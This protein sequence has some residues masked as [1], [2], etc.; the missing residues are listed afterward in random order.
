MDIQVRDVS[1][2]AEARS[3]RIDHLY[4]DEAQSGAVENRKQLKKLLRACD[5]GEIGILIIPSLDRLSRDVRIAENLFH[6][7]EQLRIRVLIADMPDYRGENRRDVL[8]RQIREAIAEDNRK[9]IIERLCKGRQERV[10]RGNVPGGT[11]PYGYVRV[12][13]RLVENT[14][15]ALVIRTIFE[16]SGLG[17]SS[18]EIAKELDDAGRKQRN[19]HQW[20]PRQVRFIL[21]RRSFYESGEL[22]YGDI[23]GTNEKLILISR[24]DDEY[25]EKIDVGVSL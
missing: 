3:L 7:F 11:A 18:S 17:Y 4:R 1:V 25:E 21:A 2:F 24:K 8:I 19:E 12:Q 16:L 20:T 13:K 10:R 23:K 22:H 15:E 14:A 6:K 9:E 5:R